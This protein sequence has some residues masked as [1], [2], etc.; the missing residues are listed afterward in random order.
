VDI[1][2]LADAILDRAAG[3]A[4][5]EV[6]VAIGAYVWGEALIQRLLEALRRR[7]F[8]GRIILGGPQVSYAADGLERIYPQA[9]AFVRGY[10]E[11]AICTLADDGGRPSIAGVH[12][13]GA[14]DLAAQAQVDLD[15]IPSPY[16]DGLIDLSNQRFARWE[17]QRG[18]PFRCSFCQHREAGARRKRRELSRTR[19]MQEL[20][21][22]CQSDVDDIAVL[23][24]I[25]NIGFL[26]EPV[27]EGFAER[28][29]LGRL[30]LQC[31]AERLTERFLEA[32]EALNCRLEFG[33]QTIRD[34]EGE[35]IKRRNN[36]AKVN[37]G[38]AEVRRRGINHEV[39]LI[40]GLPA[41]TLA[42]F[43]ETVKW[44]LDRRVPVI[45]AFPLML[46]R[47][48]ELDRERHRWSLR[49][50]G[51]AMP[52][53]IGSDSFDHA[54]WLEMARVAEAL[55]RTEGNHPT[56]LVE[57]LAIAAGCEIDEGLWLA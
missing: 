20:E 18:C 42:S 1:E 49:E 40:F 37:A 32:A 2:A 56:S 14:P 21:L 26:S 39:S 53:V 19:V 43:L 52:M 31:R 23:D 27:L 17:T 46:L 36:I 41:Q 51:G 47:G 25:F 44:C 9:T 10:G 22:F 28:G 55:R 50:T 12:Y 35:L 38:L 16:L 29:F 48:T 57:L 8:R 30:S 13:A 7:G 6:D 24:P 3:K 5:D 11:D 54:D 4:E 45:K 15:T 33:L 34:V